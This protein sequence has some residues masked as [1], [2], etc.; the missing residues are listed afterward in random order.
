MNEYLHTLKYQLMATEGLEGEKLSQ[1]IEGKD[2][3]S[4]NAITMIGE[5]RLD[6]I[7]DCITQIQ[8]DNVQGDLIEC[9]VWR[10]GASV[11]MKA[12]LNELSMSR[13]VFVADSFCGFQK[14]NELRFD[15]DK[16]ANFL[17]AKELAVSKDEVKKNFEKY[18]LL[19]ENV[20][21]I[22][23][24][25]ENTLPSFT[26]SLSLVRLDMDLYGPTLMALE[27]LYDKLSIGGFVIIDDYTSMLCCITAVEHFRQRHNV[28]E[29]IH[30]ID[31]TGAYW[32]KGR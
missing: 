12:A 19:D 10:G 8:K 13:K 4:D 9:G 26:A 27:Y 18:K 14:K 5:K 16:G 21:F 23:G 30:M 22:E 3:P 20:V 28:T 24:F 6:N 15:I 29:K 25:I 2:W 1:R 7:V 17:D 32:R 11:F 31:H